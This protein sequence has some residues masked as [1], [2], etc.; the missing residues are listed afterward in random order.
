MIRVNRVELL[1]RLEAVQPGLS[2]RQILE[3]S[4]CFV[5]K[6][7]RVV[8]FNDEVSCSTKS[9]F[10][11]DFTGAV[12]AAP[13]L[14]ILGK[15]PEET[16]KVEVKDG[17]LKVTGKNRVAAVNMD[18]E[19]LLPVGTVDPPTEWHNLHEDFEDAVKIV[20]ECAG[21]DESEFWATCIHVHP[22]Y[23]EA[24]DNYQAVR[25]KLKMGI[26]N[27]T[28]VKR[29]SLKYLPDLGMTEYSE[30]EKWIHFRNPAGLV[31]SCRHYVEDYKDLSP[32]LTVE[33]TATQLPKNIGE[34]C[35]KAEVFTAEEE[36]N[37]VRITLT[38]GMMR[39][40]GEGAKGWYKERKKVAYDGEQME[41]LISPTLLTQLAQRHNEVVV[42]PDRIMVNGGKFIYSTSL[43]LPHERPERNGDGAEKGEE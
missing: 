19:I 12:A 43:N 39:V 15:L 27:P 1:Q 17:K 10:P 6:D 25:F 21:K 37:M 32:M 35:D 18:A 41:F 16:I 14:A 29:D 33:G 3:Q 8:T 30:A 4:D 13:L 40:N 36:E 23:L 31:V 11:K 20:Q 38:K 26:S 7:G 42:A 5:F 9:P 24:C 28:L 22:K 34:A 2:P